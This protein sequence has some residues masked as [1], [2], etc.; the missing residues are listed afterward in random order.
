M[1]GSDPGARLGQ[2]LLLRNLR[3]AELDRVAELFHR[4]TFPSRTRLIQANDP[5]DTLFVVIA[6]SVKVHI[7]QLDGSEVI[8]AILGPGEVVG[9]ISVLDSLGRSASATTL[10]E[11]VLLAIARSAF[12]ESLR[13]IPAMAYNLVLILCRRL[14]LANAHIQCLA[15]LDVSSRIAVQLLSLADEYGEPQKTGSILIPMR[16]TQTDL[17]GLVGASR[18]RVNQVLVGYK[19]LGY[20]SVDRRQRFLLHDAEA[21]AQYLPDQPALP[22][23]SGASKR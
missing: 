18:V 9:E 2:T 11:S 21:L 23:R 17:A 13:T 3:E 4:R 16:L 20:V 15:T 14:R 8:L 6:G 19:R 7:A 5:G 22:T 10:E 1:T 12:W